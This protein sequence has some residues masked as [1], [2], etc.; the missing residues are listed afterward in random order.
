MQIRSVL[1]EELLDIHTYIHTEF[2]QCG[3]QYTGDAQYQTCFAGF[4]KTKTVSYWFT[5]SLLNQ[6]EEASTHKSVMTRAG[7]VFCAL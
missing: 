2:G 3:S 1:W 6:L 7:N 4:D 5:K